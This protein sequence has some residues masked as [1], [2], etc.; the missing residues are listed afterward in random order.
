MAA[1]TRTRTAARSRARTGCCTTTASPS[2]SPSP[3]A[4]SPSSGV[5]VR[6]TTQTIASK[7]H[8][9]VQGI[10]RV[11]RVGAPRSNSSRRR[12]PSRGARGDRARRH[13]DAARDD[14]DDETVTVDAT[15]RANARRRVIAARARVASTTTTGREGFCVVCYNFVFRT[16]DTYSMCTCVKRCIFPSGSTHVG[17]QTDARRRRRRP[18]RAPPSRRRPRPRACV[19]ASSGRPR[20]APS[21]ERASRERDVS[22]LDR[23]HSS[24]SSKSRRRATAVVSS[25]VTAVDW[26][27]GAVVLTCAW[28][29][30]AW[31][32]W[33]DARGARV[34]LGAGG[35]RLAGARGG[36][37]MDSERWWRWNGR[38]AGV[39]GGGG[40]AD[41]VVRGES[42]RDVRGDASVGDAARRRRRAWGR[43]RGVARA[44]ALLRSRR[45]G[46]EGS[47]VSWKL[48][49][50]LAAKNIGGGVNYVA[51]ATA[52]GMSREEFG[53]G[54]GG[55]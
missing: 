4:P 9:R 37:R 20:R 12:H 23:M 1:T 15:A 50:A 39:R 25:S 54:R 5:M 41:D 46:G 55:G 14:D 18:R 51:V 44:R 21:R 13:G 19:R 38:D 28:C 6:T 47:M 3:H 7:A 43:R 29:G 10:A 35:A 36:V 31:A 26:S 32:R 48:A 49:A 16:S 45:A 42:A 2:T 52:L 40:D 33:D 53:R 22:S 17:R 27:V 30:R 34:S 24:T 11:E 8:L